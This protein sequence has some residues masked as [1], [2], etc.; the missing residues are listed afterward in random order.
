MR[1]FRNASRATPSARQQ[2]LSPPVLGAARTTAL[3]GL[4][5]PRAARRTCDGQGPGA[6]SATT[7]VEFEPT[8]RAW[9]WPSA[10]RL[11]DGRGP[12]LWPHPLRRFQVDGVRSLLAHDSLLLAD[13]MGLGKTVQVAAALR[14]LHYAGELR[15]ALV[16]APTSLLWPWRQ[17][18][19]EWAPELD[20]LVVRAPAQDRRRI[21]T[22]AADVHLVGFETLR[23]DA[24]PGQPVLAR[25][26]SVVVLDEASRIKNP[27]AATAAACRR[28]RAAR[29]W[30]LTGT[31]LENHGGDV[32]SLLRFLQP[33]QPLLVGDEPHLLRARLTG[34][35]L[36]RR[37]A[38]VLPELPTKQVVELPLQLG[39]Q[40]AAAYR[41]AAEEGV[42]KLS[43]LGDRLT[44][45]VILELLLRLKQLCNRDPV[46]GQ[47]AKME[48]LGW[49]LRQISESGHRALVFSQFTDARFGV[50]QLS[51]QLDDLAPLLFTGEQSL[52]ERSEV[53]RR[54]QS[55]P[56]HRVLLLSLRAGGLGLNLQQASY[57][58]HLDR[59]W[60][61]A[62]EGQAEDRAHRLGQMHPVTVY[63]YLCLDTIEERIDA[64]LRHKRALFEAIIEPVSFAPETTFSKAELQQIVGLLPMDTTTTER[65]G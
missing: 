48:D 18:L 59:W 24:R 47:S 26:W 62:V 37:K 16:A 38:D 30:A 10:S 29:R 36:R 49:R 6:A 53:I 17:A 31:P 65:D 34:V 44:V 8:L 46:S 64:I 42:V 9:L 4:V 45:T 41:T 56:G 60:N 43:S 11:A 25:E 19:A 40:Q 21:W 20:V 55:D 51:I 23:V 61:P 1:R 5:I 35:Q 63:R 15:S 7:A 13:D 54:F 22:T 2:P 39:E 12:L 57:V 14:L 28:L 58:F 50:Q 3:D 27:Y 52:A 33:E 32:A